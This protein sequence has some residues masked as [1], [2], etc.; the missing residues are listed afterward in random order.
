V[1]GACRARI[2]HVIILNVSRRLWAIGLTTVLVASCSS[3]DSGSINAALV[4]AEDLPGTWEYFES[5]P[6]PYRTVDLCGQPRT[7]PTPASSAATGWAPTPDDGPIFGERI[8]R[9]ASSDDLDT[10]VNHPLDVPCTFTRED[11]GRWRTEQVEGFELG[12]DS[13]VY[14]VTSLDRPDSFNY[15]VLIASDAVALLTVLNTRKPDRALLDDLVQIAWSKAVD[16][17]VVDWR[18]NCRSAPPGSR[19]R[20]AHNDGAEPALWD[21]AEW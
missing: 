21:T 2:D 18:Q 4:S 12:D 5:T 8:E 9:F 16:E 19:L 10:L 13:R 17:G 11:G 14:L 3:G 7:R 20:R 1:F 15:Q 6:S